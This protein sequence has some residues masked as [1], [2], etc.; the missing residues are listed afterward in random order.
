MK[1]S[2]DRILTSHVGSLVRPDSIKDFTNAIAEGKDIDS[3]AYEETL[4]TEVR[5]VVRDQV[6][7]KVDVVS[8]GEFGKYSWTAYSLGRLTGFEM[9]EDPDMLKFLG[10]DLERFKDFY[11]ESLREQVARMGRHQVMSKWMC[12]GPIKYTD[13]GRELMR[14]D[15]QNLKDA[16]E[17]VTVAGAF[18][19]VAAPCSIAPSYANEYYKSEEEFLFALAEAQHEEYKIITDAG[20]IVQVDDAILTNLYNAVVDSGQDYRKWVEM[21]VEALNHA[22]RG[23]PEEQVRYHLCWGSW[24]GPHISDVPFT[25]IVDLLLKINAQGYSIE[26]ANPRHEHEWMVWET[27]KLPEGKILLPGC[28]SHAIAH[29]EHPELVAQRIMRFANLVGRENVIASTDCGFAQGFGISRQHP[30]IVWA[31]LEALAE[32][33]AIATKRLWGKQ[34]SAAE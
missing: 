21:N 24:P 3:K 7:H 26:A 12:V 34:A 23:I 27:T 22:L 31:K 30:E 16:I 6:T 14:R 4:H 19:P 28:I 29:V 13:Q 18:L 11:E 8:D 5:N 1:R 10:H 20:L 25:E 17:D 2:S 9:R 32:G 15:V 33:A